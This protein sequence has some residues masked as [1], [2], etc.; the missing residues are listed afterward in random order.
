MHSKVP[1]SR[2]D[3]IQSPRWVDRSPHKSDYVLS[4]GVRLNYL[5]WGGPG[6]DLVLVHGY[7]GNPHDFDD[8]ATALASQFHV[9]AYARRGHGLSDAKGPFDTPT[10]SEDLRG[11]LDALGIAKAHLAGWSMG[12]NEMTHLAGAHPERVDRLVYLDAAYDWGDPEA[13]QVFARVPVSITP[14]PAALS[15]R[16]AY[17]NWWRADLIPGLGGRYPFEAALHETFIVQPD[18]SLKPRTDPSVLE[19]IGVALSNDRRDYS[20][21]RSPALAIYAESFYDVQHG[22]PAQ[23]AKNLAWE[24]E[25]VIPFRQ[26]S[27]D[28]VRHEL[29]GAQI[30]TVPGTHLDFP[31]SSEG[32]VLKLMR[33]FLSAAPLAGTED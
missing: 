27:M 9:V 20:R 4:K 23:R 19:E 12:G 1:G 30:V 15:S 31:F 26:R 18:G 17:R 13:R 32:R 3:R 6:P 25:Y 16:D 10:L 14:P 2:S 29:S 22:D 21:V 33:R 8:L 11:L 7:F 5:D 24:R 28:R